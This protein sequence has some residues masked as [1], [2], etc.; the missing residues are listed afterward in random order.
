M[1][2]KF[3]IGDRVSTYN[4]W[5]G[6]IIDEKYSPITGILFTVACG[7]NGLGY[8]TATELT[9][10]EPDS[11]TKKASEQFTVILKSGVTIS[12]FTETERREIENAMKVKN[13]RYKNKGV[14]IF[15]NDVAAI[16][17]DRI[18]INNMP[19]ELN[20]SLLKEY[21]QKNLKIEINSTNF[22]FESAIWLDR[23]LITKDE[24]DSR[25]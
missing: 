21:L 6:L 11:I 19:S 23:D 7:E 5:S 14:A 22:G 15:I 20:Y 16:V 2:R 3:K 13:Y 4:K 17:P 10:I 25:W 1:E 24:Y 8:F 12:G 9:L 18:E